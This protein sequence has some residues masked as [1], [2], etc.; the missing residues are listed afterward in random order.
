MRSRFHKQ[1]HPLAH[2]QFATFNSV[3]RLSPKKGASDK[4]SPPAANDHYLDK[5]RVMGSEVGDDQYAD[6]G[7]FVD[8]MTLWPPVRYGHISATSYSVLA[9]TASGKR[10]TRSPNFLPT[11]LRQPTTQQ[12]FPR[13][14]SSR[15]SHVSIVTQHPPW[16]TKGL[17]FPLLP[18]NCHLKFLHT[19]ALKIPIHACC[20]LC[21]YH[22]IHHY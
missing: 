6:D 14:E 11:L 1:L 13:T 17:V 2:A 12:L 10:K 8:D 21:A 15:K 22:I 5:L 7:R 3:Q 9:Y 4:N 16:P 20:A 18:L 19:F